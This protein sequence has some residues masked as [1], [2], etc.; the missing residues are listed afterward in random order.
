M[1]YPIW[2]WLVL[3]LVGGPNYAQSLL[4]LDRLHPQQELLPHLSLAVDSSASLD[5]QDALQL[6]FQALREDPNQLSPEVVWWVKIPLHNALD[7]PSQWMYYSPTVGSVHLFAVDSL[8]QLVFTSLSGRYVR[9]ADKP[10]NEGDFIHIPFQLKARQSVT[11]YL[12]YKEENLN[13]VKLQPILYERSHWLAED[14]NPRGPVILFFQGIFFIMI[15][16]NLI[17]FFSIGFRAYLYYALY[18]LCISVFVSFAVGFMSYPP[19]GDPL[20]LEPIGILAMGAINLFYFLFGR[21]LLNLPVLYPRWDRLI[22]YYIYFKIGMLALVQAWVWTSQDVGQAVEVEFV[23]LAI[24]AVLSLG[25]MVALLRTRNRVA[26]YFVAGSFSVIVLGMSLAAIGHLNNL[27][28]TFVIFLASIVVEIIFFSLGLGYRISQAE[29]EKLEAERGKRKAQE[30]LNQELSK[31]NTAFGRFVPHEF[32]R[33]LGHDSILDVNL[34]DGVEREVTVL[35][36][37]IRDY[38]TL[39]EQ[40][41]PQENF[42]FLNAYLGRVG[43]VISEN[44]GFVNQYYGDGVMALFL[45][46]ADQ[47][48]TAAIEM[49]KTLKTYNEGRLAKGKEA[50]RIGIGIHTGSLMMGV[51]GDALRMDAG[52]VSDTV[53]TASRMEGLTKQF[54]VEIVVS[55][56]TLALMQDK[57]AF[58]HSLLGRVQVKGRQQ[59]LS[60][61]AFGTEKREVP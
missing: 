25:L 58:R 60:V 10:L 43:P 3:L 20:L 13:P 11:L 14:H 44:G 40:M 61:Y 37:D 42:R 5:W 34:G 59:P 51:I 53:N 35:F 24:D 55:E 29:R 38:T 50:I 27:P 26:T 56:S 15:L 18:L 46:Q 6:P 1:R 31:I 8:Q 17:L 47:A 32:L 23:M 19:F 52:V 33:S 22:Q 54:G 45:K 9:A 30:A 41:S 36:S 28:Y 39:S 4:R 49:L 57:D 48:V 12:R 7:F 21:S 16:Y 2:L